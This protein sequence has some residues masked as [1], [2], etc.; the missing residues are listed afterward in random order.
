M[1]IDSTKDPPCKEF[2]FGGK[3]LAGGFLKALDKLFL[4][5]GYNLVRWVRCVGR[6]CSY[7]MQRGGQAKLLVW[8]KW[9]Q[10]KLTF[11][12]MGY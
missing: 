5:R 3:S 11:S 2:R 8:W 7:R 10:G 6:G 4:D 1:V 9:L 12:K